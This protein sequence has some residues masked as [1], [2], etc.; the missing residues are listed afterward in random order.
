MSQDK[1]R[2]Y[3]GVLSAVHTLEYPYTRSVGKV[4]GT[5]LAGLR[6]GR[7]LGM[8]RASGEVLVPP[9]EYDPATS[10]SLTEMCDVSDAG[11]VT[12]WSWVAEPRAKH[13][14]QKPF[15]WALIR[16]DGAATGLLHAIDA[17]DEKTMKTGMRVKARWRAER[18]G[19]ITDIECFV[20]ESG[21]GVQS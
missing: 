21:E 8:R 14:L 20:A 1:L 9:S 7:I 15:A 16:L 3:Q 13:P 2:H 18:K 11:V 17:G 5:F 19:M 4:I 6:D 10:E 12:T